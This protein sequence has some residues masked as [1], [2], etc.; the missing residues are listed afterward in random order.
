[1]SHIDMYFFSEIYI[2]KRFMLFKADL[3]DF[4]KYRKICKIHK[5]KEREIGE[6]GVEGKKG[7]REL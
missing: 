6:K 5:K 3:I 4:E 2:L 7:G 1:M